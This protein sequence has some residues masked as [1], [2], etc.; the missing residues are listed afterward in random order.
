MGADV[1]LEVGMS[2]VSRQG[3]SP[4]LGRVGVTKVVDELITLRTNLATGL[5]IPV[6]LKE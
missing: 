1:Q 5:P 4:Q 3:V 6:F 2:P